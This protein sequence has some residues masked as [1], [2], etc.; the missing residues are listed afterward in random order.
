LTPGTGIGSQE[1]I[2]TR[3]NIPKMRDAHAW[4]TTI[5][6]RMLLFP[7]APLSARATHSR[8]T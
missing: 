1:S 7:I 3:L 2:L 8:C 6:V 4:L 5:G